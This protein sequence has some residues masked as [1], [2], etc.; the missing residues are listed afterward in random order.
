MLFNLFGKKDKGHDGRIFKD[1]VW[2]GTEQKYHALKKIL[3]QDKEVLFVAW[4]PA[5]VK[6]FREYL[7]QEDPEQSNVLEAKFVHSNHVQGRKVIFIEHYP[8]HEKEIAF[9]QSLNLTE[10]VVYSA[11]DEPFFKHLGSDKVIPMMKMMG[12]KEDEAI[13][14]SMVTKAIM[15]GQD[16]FAAKVSV[17]Q[18]A[19]SQEEWIVKNLK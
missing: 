5:T 11:L 8:L 1:V 3:Q 6:V 9:A 16:K 4:F 14:H 19:N 7:Q 13:E 18:A 15:N 17:D 10:A 2:A 12:M